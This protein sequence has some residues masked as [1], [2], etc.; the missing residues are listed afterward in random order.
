M[1][2]RRSAPENGYACRVGLTRRDRKCWLCQLHGTSLHESLTILCAGKTRRPPTRGDQV[3]FKDACLT[4][5]LI[6]LCSGFTV[7]NDSHV[8]RPP[9][10]A[11]RPRSDLLACAIKSDQNAHKSCLCDLVMCATNIN[12]S[13]RQSCSCDVTSW[14][15]SQ[16]STEYPVD[17]RTLVLQH[18]GAQRRLF[19][20]ARHR[21]RMHSPLVVM[22][23]SFQFDATIFSRS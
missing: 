7:N 17:A 6:T 23:V 22:C 3:P 13:T 15:V 16:K 10:A 8:K 14:C 4:V 1:A 5:K 2:H 18:V 21:A 11:P 19:A 9:G 20:S 12:W